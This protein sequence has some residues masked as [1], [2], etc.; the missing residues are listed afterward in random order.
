[1]DK[2]KQDM[3]YE[4][5]LQLLIVESLEESYKTVVKWAMNL[6]GGKYGSIFEVKNGTPVRV[7]TSDP[8][9]YKLIPRKN[10]GTYNVFQSAKP[11]L[12]PVSEIAPFHPIINKMKIAS[13]ISV[14]LKYDKEKIGV[15]SVLSYADKPFT[16]DD[17]EAIKLFAPLASYSI[18]QQ[19]LQDDL[20]KTLAERDLF[21]SMA[22][23]EIRT[24]L[25]SIYV[26]SQYFAKIADGANPKNSL[27]LGKIKSGVERLNGLINDFLSVQQI[28]TRSITYNFE[29]VDLIK[30]I[31]D[32]IDYFHFQYKLH[33]VDF[34]YNP[35]QKFIIQGDY[36]KLHQAMTNIL[37]NAGKYSVSSKRISV[38]LAK[39]KD[40][41]EVLISDRGQ[42]IKK[43]DQ[44]HIFEKFYRSKSTKKEGMGIGLYLTKN[45]VEA[46]KGQITV[47]SKRRKGTT[48]MI[49][50]PGYSNERKSSSTS[51]KI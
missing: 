49:T 44:S 28:N 47:D 3:F 21:I 30:L 40:L 41:L 12:R 51:R 26:Y 14:P 7:Y 27:Y 19:K 2:R 23:H 24:P 35:N 46:H 43:I 1:M 29:K 4:A 22:A 39:K 20:K 10:G 42:G 45:I 37:K 50:L 16:E 25:T 8:K 18:K 34:F 5:S 11:F 6:V 38:T 9:L 33:N 48:F 36:G 15:L 31:K 17:L 13:D 32:A